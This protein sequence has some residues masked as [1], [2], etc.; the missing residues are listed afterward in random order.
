M[1]KTLPSIS[2]RTEAFSPRELELTPPPE[3]L[4]RAVVPE[5]RAASERIKDKLRRW[6]EQEL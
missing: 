3:P 1:P 4:P 5:R 6:L 2:T